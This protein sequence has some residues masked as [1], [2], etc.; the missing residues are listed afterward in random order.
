MQVNV[1]VPLDE[2]HKRA[3]KA[4]AVLDALNTKTPQEIN[5]YINSKTA[6]PDLRDLFQALFIGVAALM[7]DLE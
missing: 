2:Q 7:R 3:A 1:E 5:T 4:N 6:D